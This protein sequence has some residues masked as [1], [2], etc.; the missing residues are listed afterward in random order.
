MNVYKRISYI[1]NMNCM[2]P[3]QVFFTFIMSSSFLQQ[4]EKTQLAAPLKLRRQLIQ[5][6]EVSSCFSLW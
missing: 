4:M 6:R 2:F 3:T 1:L 5:V